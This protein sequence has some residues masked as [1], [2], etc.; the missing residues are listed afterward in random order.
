[1]GSLAGIALMAL[2]AASAGIA[3]P[4]EMSGLVAHYTFDEA[5]GDVL[6]DRSGH[7]HDGRIVGAE[8]VERNG[9]PELR[10]D[11]SGDYV[12]FGDNRALKR[13]GDL[14]FL[15]WVY[16]DASPCPDDDTNW[17]IIDCEDYRKEGF[18]LRIDGAASKAMYRVSQI[19]GD[20]GSFGAIAIENHSACMMAVTRRDDTATIYVDG[21]F[22]ARFT[23][24]D[25][26]FGAIPF[27]ISSEEQSFNGTIGEVLVFD[28]A[29]TG[30]EIIGHYWR[31]AVRYGKDTSRR[32]RLDLK[33]FVYYDD[34]E[35]RAEVDFF[36]V[37]PVAADE[38]VLI[39]LAIRGGAALTS[40]EVP[41]VGE[42]GMSTAVFSMADLEPGQYELRC[43]LTGPDRTARAVAPFEY[44]QP[45]VEVPS[46]GACAVDPLPAAPEPPEHG[47]RV[48]NG[49]GFFIEAEARSF[50]VESSF[51]FPHGGDNRLVCAPAADAG[52]EP[53][54]TV[55][56][57]QD[58]A[59]TWA[60]EAQGAYYALSRRIVA[61]P[62]RVVVSDT[63]TNM[64]D[65]PVGILISNGVECNADGFD[66]AFLAGMETVTPV[67]GREL[68]T[69]PALLAA[70]PGLGLGLVALDDVYIVQ[71]RGAFDGRSAS[72]SSSEFA[73]DAGASYTLEWAVYVNTTGD[74]YDLINAVRRDEGRNNVTVDGS[75]AFIPET[76]RRRDV[77]LVPPGEYFDTRNAAYATLYCLSW[78]TDDPTISLEG[79]EF[80]EYPEERQRIRAMMD[81]MAAVRPEVKGMFHVAQQLYATGRPEE[82]WPDSRVVD[83]DG[84]HAVYPYNY[85][86]G[87]YFSKERYDDNWRWWIYYPTLDNSFGKALLDSVD[88]MMDDMGC[89][90]VFV[91]GFLWGYGG[92]YTYDRW[93]GHS[94]D[95][96]PKTRAI[97]R[98]K[99]STLLLTQDVMAA[100]C[101]KVWDKGGVVI[102]NNTI[103]T[104]TICSLPLIVDKEISEGPYV[105]LAPTPIALGNPG[106]IHSEEDV[107]RDV[108]SKLR[109]GNLYFY[110][111][112]PA[113]LT[114]ESVPKQ[115][116]PI[117]VE[118]IH[119]GYV[120]GRERLVTMH[121]GV[122][123]WPGNRDLHM[124]YRYDSRGHRMRPDYVTTV[125]ASSVRTRIDLAD[126]EA[127]VLARIPVQ[128]HSSGPVN[129]V[130]ERYD[131][132]KVVMM[133]NGKGPVRVTPPNGS[134]YTLDL[135]GPR[136]IMLLAAPGLCW[137]LVFLPQAGWTS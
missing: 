85:D 55:S 91:D 5:S 21:L 56:R 47:V 57:R 46:P 127:A 74:H 39:E 95:I 66:R 80:V 48:T 108:L 103:P 72:L 6:H 41:A 16:L 75:L 107:Y 60:V 68:K 1:M 27:K 36:G 130:V 58:T 117:T 45:P 38:K 67:A 104:R 25:P 135:N 64:S 111:G 121:S 92:E 65:A 11:G 19:G 42:K 100:Y 13:G 132:K 118:E 54:W 102:A 90:G 24:E 12:D 32:G 43:S 119:S 76:Q 31:G 83:A 123:G 93:D 82:L 84:N 62:G 116:Y 35:A 109:W 124:A 88:V 53:T 17:T 114:Y 34:A 105:H 10:F 77:D 59:S 96:D 73:L 99:G 49:G 89:R 37:L 136:E 4:G 7:G 20:N 128:V 134:A 125:D 40:R 106:A 29:L 44:P 122:Y 51:S 79:I 23:A 133:L 110:Y 33:P 120:K 28:R 126:S 131:E 101:R 61:E 113:T 115:M 14:T 3:A 87:T 9:N 50:P 71:S 2:T 70:S 22:D 30:D 18:I 86:S 98:K 94:A 15:A 112:D 26:V 81:A 129:V 52:G 97:S 63:L 137:M 69:C 8:W 78:C